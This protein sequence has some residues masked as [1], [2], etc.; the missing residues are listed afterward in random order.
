[1]IGYS[2]V[3]ANTCSSY[4]FTSLFLQHILH[5]LQTLRHKINILLLIINSRKAFPVS[6]F[7][8]G[9]VLLSF[10]LYGVGQVCVFSFYA[11]EG[12][13]SGIDF[14]AAFSWSFVVFVEEP[15]VFILFDLFRNVK[16]SGD[17]KL[18]SSFVVAGWISEI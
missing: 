10:R 16:A 14:I 9:S 7:E 2:F 13:G 12:V 1:M 8:Q 15:I 4:K 6:I 5:A 18:R 11:A 3:S 17:A